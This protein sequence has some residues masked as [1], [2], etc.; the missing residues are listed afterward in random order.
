[1]KHYIKRSALFSILILTVC[2]SYAATPFFTITPITAGT[3][4]APELITSGQTIAATYQIT[5][6]SGATLSGLHLD[7]RTL[8]ANNVVTQDVSS[9]TFADQCTATFTLA[10]NQSCTLRLLVTSVVDQSAQTYGT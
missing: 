10:N 5:N 3:K 1:M 7:S 9:S 4:T 6:T 2:S 8:P